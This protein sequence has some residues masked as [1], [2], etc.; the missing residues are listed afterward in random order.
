[1][2]TTAVT[3]AQQR[4]A[5]LQ[6]ERLPALPTMLGP[7]AVEMLDAAVAAAGGHVV[8]ARPVQVSWSPGR[9]LF[10]RYHAKV[11]G[12]QGEASDVALVAAT[13][14]DAPRGVILESDGARV[15][16][17]K[18]EED[19]WLPGLAVLMDPGGARRLLDSLGVPRGPLRIR[20][21]AYRPSN[22]A[23][24]Q[25][26]TGG[27]RLFAKVVRPSQVEALQ[28]R[29]RAMAGVLPV[30]RS[31]G[32]SEEHG[33]IV[34]EGMPGRTLRET[35]ADTRAPFPSPDAL[36]ELLDRLPELPEPR[37]VRSPIAH[38][39]GHAA[40]LA[41]L[42]SNEA[43][44]LSGLVDRIGP[45]PLAGTTPVHGDFHE[46][47]LLV[48][49]GRLTAL[50]DVDTAGVGRRVDDWA[51]LIGHL[52]AWQGSA[53]RAA[54][55]RIRHYIARA[56][57]AAESDENAEDLWRTVA[58]VHVGLATGPFRAQSADWPSETRRRI[59]LAEVALDWAERS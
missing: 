21:R 51:T 56:A 34:L 53:P 7:D 24:V 44:R 5:A 10:V 29:H 48:E 16:A 39:A 43:E 59:A 27:L 1:M 31:H 36:R 25:L 45:R 12:A 2:E 32:W 37:R 14:I 50:L 47:Q 3:E 49:G 18:L 33:V 40:L 42:L 8:D 41:R 6:D 4:T 26:D 11:E 13:G 22:R 9:Q 57:R 46:A 17:W 30:P 19:P 58:A 20:L 15:A 28:D 55:E 23:V 52:E 35:L 38:A 54:H